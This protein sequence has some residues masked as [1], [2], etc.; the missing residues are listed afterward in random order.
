MEKIIVVGGD[1]FCGWPTSLQL[2]SEGYEVHIIDNLS[3]RSIDNELNSMSLTPIA[4]VER[5]IKKA[6][7]LI[8]NIKFHKIDVAEE[9]DKLRNIIDEVKP[10]AIIQFAEQRAAPYSMISDKERCYTVDNNIKGTHNI[11]SAIVDI[12][13]DIHLIH[14]GTM[15]VYGY[16][17]EYGAIPEGYLNIKINQTSKDVDV[18]YPANP[19]SIYHMTKCLDQLI[20]QFYNKNW[21]L[22]ITDLHQGIVWGISTECTLKHEDLANR[23]DF[24]G[25]Y[26]TVLNRFIVQAANNYPLSV[27]GTGGQ[28]RAFIHISDTAKCLSLAIKNKPDRNKVRIFN[29]VAEVKSVKQLAELIGSKYGSKIS[30]IDN[31]RN[32]LAD[33]EL[34]VSNSGLLSLGFEPI[35]LTDKLIEDIYILADQL[36]SNFNEDLVLTSPKW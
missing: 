15:G 20:F 1:G 4:S 17:K 18:L 3:R 34:E 16:S 13:K 9:R 2:S 21:G 30:Q 10:N 5:R 23:F 33:N 19:G 31:P 24:D 25:I 28:T 26:G 11:C 36:T 14:L 29:Q 27:Y 7:E 6:N 32:E 22:K 8:G 12:D 35:L